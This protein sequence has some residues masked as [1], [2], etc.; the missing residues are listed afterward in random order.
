MDYIIIFFRDILDGPLY[1]IVAIISGILICSCIGYLAEVNINKKKIK[2]EYEKK[3]ADVNSNTISSNNTNIN[4]NPPAIAIQNNMDN[5]KIVNT[6]VAV[7]NNN[8]TD[9]QINQP[10]LGISIDNIQND[11]NQNIGK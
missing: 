9:N 11:P 1:I 10:M 3:Y 8:P 2:Q 4:T 6:N 7:S 5:N